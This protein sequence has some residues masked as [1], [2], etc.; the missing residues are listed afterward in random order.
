MKFKK[1]DKVK[2]MAFNPFNFE[3]R[4]WLDGIVVSLMEEF[5]ELKNDGKEYYSVDVKGIKPNG[6]YSRFWSSSDGMVKEGE[7]LPDINELVDNFIKEAKE[8]VAR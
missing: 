6:E 3:N 5:T 8:N 4:K 7:E 2:V 1:G